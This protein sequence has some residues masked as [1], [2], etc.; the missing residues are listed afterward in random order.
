MDKYKKVKKDRYQSFLFTL[1]QCGKFL[2]NATNEEI[3]R[4]IFEEFD[5]LA[6]T[7]LSDELLEMFLEEGWI[8]DSILEKCKLLRDLF[9]DIQP[10]YPELWNVYS[11]RKERKW[12]KILNL[13]DEIKAL[14]YY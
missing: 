12:E 7:Y 1:K 3:E 2:V 10:H 8:D 5:I 6:R 14:L 13:A 4:H 11:V 9:I